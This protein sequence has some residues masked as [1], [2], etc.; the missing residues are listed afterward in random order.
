MRWTCFFIVLFIVIY[1]AS[2]SKKVVGIEKDIYNLYI[3]NFDEYLEYNGDNLTVNKEKLK[4][5][6]EGK[7]C[8]VYIYNDEN[9]HFKIELK[10]PYRY[11]KEY[12][13]YL[14]NTYE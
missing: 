5:Y 1:S 2:N 7:D 13:F 9:L 3:K 4:H 8:Y 10:F 12:V 11:T 6:L 14:V